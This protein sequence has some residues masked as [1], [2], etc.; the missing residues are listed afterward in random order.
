MMDLRPQFKYFNIK[1]N[2]ARPDAK[3]ETPTRG[4]NDGDEPQVKGK[5]RNIE[6]NEC[7][8]C[9]GSKKI[10]AQRNHIEAPTALKGKEKKI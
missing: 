7:V 2:F 5:L 3:V 10:L 8:T 9:R 4:G 1:R 6:A